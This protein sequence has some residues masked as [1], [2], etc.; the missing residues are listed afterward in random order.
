MENV[1]TQHISKTPNVCGGR[2]CITGHRIRVMDIVA[3]HEMRG[4]A[5]DQI[6]D[7]FPGITLGDVH[8]ALAYYFDHR[9]EIE[10][11][12]RKEEEA[13]EWVKD[14]IPSKIPSELKGRAGV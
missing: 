9:S 10:D 4:M 8:A 5:P 11:E 1:L 14:N 7:M 2:A 6:V 3:W 13:G 12:F